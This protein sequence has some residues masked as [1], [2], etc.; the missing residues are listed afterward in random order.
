MKLNVQFCEGF[1]ND[2]SLHSS[3]QRFSF[4]LG[5]VQAV[6]VADA[7]PYEGDYTV[8]PSAIEQ[9]LTTRDKRMLDNVIV[10]S[11]PFIETSN[12]NGT[13]VYIG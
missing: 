4:G 9:T 10:K 8:T 7:P 1:Q 11:I 2:I 3:N 13:T 6:T 5:E 12:D